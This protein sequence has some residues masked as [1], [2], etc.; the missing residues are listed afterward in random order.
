MNIIEAK[1]VIGNH[2]IYYDYLGYER[3]GIVGFI[4]PYNAPDDTP[5]E[6]SVVWVY[7][8]DDDP[9]YNVHEFIYN[10][11]GNM[12]CPDLRHLMY[13]EMRLSTEVILDTDKD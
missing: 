6:G 12:Q 7:I 3:T 1:D 5:G 13:A 11:N 10:A 9:D 2:V 4:E 8:V